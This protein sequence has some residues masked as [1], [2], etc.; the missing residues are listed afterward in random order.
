MDGLAAIEAYAAL[1]NVAPPYPP[2]VELPA[3]TQVSDQDGI[4]ALAAAVDV[5]QDS[6]ELA[7]LVEAA[8]V[9]RDAPR[10]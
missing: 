4:N 6:A 1:E 3:G 8:H 10:W 9:L 2:L 5:A 7:R